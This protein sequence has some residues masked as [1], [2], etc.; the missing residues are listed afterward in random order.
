MS[1]IGGLTVYMYIPDDNYYGHALSLVL[2]Q[3]NVMKTTK[4]LHHTSPK[5]DFT[6]LRAFFVRG[7]VISA[8]V[9]VTLVMR[10]LI[11]NGAPSDKVITT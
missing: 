5:S 6:R 9:L 10:L 3:L 8:A 1:F 2:A 4:H 11:S 7:V